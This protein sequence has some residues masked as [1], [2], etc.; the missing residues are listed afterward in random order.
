MW[1]VRSARAR[2][3]IRPDFCEI[4]VNL[5]SDTEYIGVLFNS[6]KADIADY[7]S[8]VLISETLR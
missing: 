4:E 8:F 3:E 1:E 7:M 6:K 5:R 2:N